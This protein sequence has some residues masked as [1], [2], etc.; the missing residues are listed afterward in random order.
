MTRTVDRDLPKCVYRSRCDT[1]FAVV[2]HNGHRYSLGTFKTVEEAEA[3]VDLFRE[4]A[5][6]KK[7]QTWHPGDK[8]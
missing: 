4:Q 1:Y 2:R 5:P 6:P 8:I 3:R 7:T